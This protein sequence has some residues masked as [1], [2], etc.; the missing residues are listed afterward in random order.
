[1]RL[2]QQRGQG[3]RAQ[4]R[5][6][7]R[8]SVSLYSSRDEFLE[9]R[10]I[11][12]KARQTL[13][14][15]RPAARWTPSKEVIRRVDAGD[16]LAL[17]L[18]LARTV[19]VAE[20]KDLD[21]DPELGILDEEP[22]AWVGTVDK[23]VSKKLKEKEIKRQE[24][25][26]EFIITEKHHCLTL[27]VMQKVGECRFAFRWR[28]GH[29]SRARLLSFVPGRADLRGRDA[30][31]AALPAG[32]GR[33]AVPVPRGAHRVPLPVPAPAAP[34]PA[35]GG[36]RG[37]HR[38]HPAAAVL[39][40]ARRPAALALRRVLLPPP[41]GRLHVQGHG[42][43]GPQVRRVRAPVHHEPAVQE[44]GHSGVHPVRDAAHHQ[45]PAA[46][47]PAH[48]DV[49][50]AAG[51]VPQAAASARLRQGSTRS[52]SAPVRLPF[53]SRSAP[54][55]SGSCGARRLGEGRVPRTGHFFTLSY[56]Y[57]RG[58]RGAARCPI[59]HV[60]YPLARRMRAPRYSIAAHD[61]FPSRLCYSGVS[62]LL[63]ISFFLHS[64]HFFVRRVDFLFSFFPGHFGRRELSGGG[65]GAQTSPH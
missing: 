53:G 26:Y 59:G 6:R 49:A 28:D 47:R 51:G 45:V 7:S 65:E 3:R 38:G 32:H 10:F 40:A 21:L 63:F 36:R 13:R 48:Q 55:V 11:E 54:Q 17:I 12:G 60:T 30:P 2:E 1:M 41:G 44:K 22:E 37:E 33:P 5:A 52:R 24:H 20:V 25:I 64:I 8:V 34:A 46:H 57:R 27:K 31:R 18:C 9:T 50:R 62:L 19:N 39:R 23:K 61:T 35:P 56:R 29:L 58:P 42:E 16:R 4:R 14:D 43:G 15:R